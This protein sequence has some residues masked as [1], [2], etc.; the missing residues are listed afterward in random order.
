MSTIKERLNFGISVSCHRMNYDIVFALLSPLWW[1][2]LKGLS[3]GIFLP[4]LI[5]LIAMWV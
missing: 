2:L 4:F 3:D 5:Y 1:V